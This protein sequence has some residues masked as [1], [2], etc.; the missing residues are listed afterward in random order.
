MIFRR[1]QSCRDSRNVRDCQGL[2]LGQ[3]QI[4][5]WSIVGLGAVKLFCKLHPWQIQDIMHFSKLTELQDTKD[6]SIVP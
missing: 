6:E 2:G 3:G 4:N 5:R 1:K